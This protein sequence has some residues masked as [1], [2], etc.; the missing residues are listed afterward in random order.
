MSEIDSLFENFYNKITAIIVRTELCVDS[1]LYRVK[2]CEYPE[3]SMPMLMR[4]RRLMFSDE[5]D[6]FL[7]GGGICITTDQ[8]DVRPIICD[9]RAAAVLQIFEEMRIIYDDKKIKGWSGYCNKVL[10]VKDGFYN[11]MKEMRNDFAHSLK[12]NYFEEAD[13]EEAAEVA[14]SKV[15]TD[16]KRFGKCL[17]IEIKQYTKIQTPTKKELEY[18]N[19]T[20]QKMSEFLKSRTFT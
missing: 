4:A 1:L 5:K 7:G 19:K 14:L 17:K 10:K 6:S 16:L 8:K 9:L 12:D 18:N 3:M 13:L 15:Y 11:K 2:S 20:I